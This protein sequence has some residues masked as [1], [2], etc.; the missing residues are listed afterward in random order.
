[1][2]FKSTVSFRSSFCKIR[3]TKLYFTIEGAEYSHVQLHRG[4]NLRFILKPH[5]KNSSLWLF[6]SHKSL[7]LSYC[8]PGNMKCCLAKLDRVHHMSRKPSHFVHKLIHFHTN[9]HVCTHRKAIEHLFLFVE[10]TPVALLS[11]YPAEVS[12]ETGRWCL[13]GLRQLLH[14]AVLCWSLH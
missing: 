14:C 12:M 4:D 3:L 8:R 5:G 1:M 6:K 11:V 7:K 13:P 10:L 9:T 2:I